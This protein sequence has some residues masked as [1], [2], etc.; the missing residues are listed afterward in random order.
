MGVWSGVGVLLCL[1]AGRTQV[2]LP[3]IFSDGLV[4]TRDARAPVWGRAEPGARV[5][6]QASWMEAPVEALADATGRWQV[7]VP[8]P[9]AGGPHELV[10][11]APDPI[12]VRDVWIGE[13][14]LAA[15]QSNMQW[16]LSKSE[17][18]RAAIESADFP[19]IRVFDVRNP[20]AM[21]P[22]RDCIGDWRPCKPWKVGRF[23]AVA[24]HFAVELQ[25]ELDVPIGV[26][27][28]TWSGTPAAA[29]TSATTLGARGDFDEALQR[30]E[31]ALEDDEV[32]ARLAPPRHPGEWPQDHWF[33]EK[34]PTSLFNGLIAPVRPF[35]I[36]GVIWYQGEADVAE[37]ETYRSL[38]PDLIADWRGQWGQGDF[39]FLFVQIAPYAY[40]GDTGQAARLREAQ[41]AALA[42]PETGMVVTMDLGDTDD[43]HAVDKLAVG[44]RLARLALARTYGR[45]GLRCEGPR[46]RSMEV[47][48]DRIRIELDH[49]EGL[50]SGGAAPT[51]FTVAGED[52][53][54]HPA[55]ATIE[56]ESVV[57]GSPEVARPVAVRFAF[58]AADAPNLVNG[59]G[60]PA[61]PFRTDDWD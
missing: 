12:V 42:V 10:V 23:S 36:R 57:V 51:C 8:T 28:A 61:A 48:G 55:A 43:I 27:T 45:D 56:G 21:A 49:A 19:R 14:W 34:H 59:A 50:A 20:P 17:G 3:A 35:G 30:I 7:E 38:F 5:P 41:E 60:L 46:Y 58:G 15:G 53:V 24:F 6:V 29:W 4:L 16:P 40:P 54:F 11:G 13:V 44:Q 1:A 32:A 52:R 22:A 37:A 25:R 33:Q 31:Q 47:V 18:A 26:I 39:P 9:G 2:E